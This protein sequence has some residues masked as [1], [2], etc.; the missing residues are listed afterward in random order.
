MSVFE[1]Y[2]ESELNKMINSYKKM[3]SREQRKYDKKKDDEDFKIKNRMRARAHYMNNKDKKAIMYE[4]DK[5]LLK[6]RSL[7]NYY[8]NNDRMDDFISKHPLKVQLLKDKGL[9]IMEQQ[10][11]VQQEEDSAQPQEAQ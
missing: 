5:E 6:S 1:E 8:K 2:S 7:Y 11:E 4:S 10:Q 3:K 9:F